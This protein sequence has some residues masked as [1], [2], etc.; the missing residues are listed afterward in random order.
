MSIMNSIKE[1][2]G[3]PD[4]K[5]KKDASATTSAYVDWLPNYMI[6]AAISEV[7]IDS[8]LPLPGAKRFSGEV[9]DAATVVNRLKILS[10]L[11]PVKYDTP[12][13]GR[14]TQLSGNYCFTLKT[15]FTDKNGH[16]RCSVAL[17]AYAK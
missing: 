1:L 4:E 15:A 8:N 14:F 13:A 5:G 16:S 3:F 2:F 7:I 6:G 17:S 9:P 10:G 11:S 12:Q